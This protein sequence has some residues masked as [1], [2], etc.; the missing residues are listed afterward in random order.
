MH[1]TIELI[2]LYASLK[3]CTYAVQLLWGLVGATQ[4]LDAGRGTCTYIYATQPRVLV[5][6]RTQRKSS[7]SISFPLNIYTKYL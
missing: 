1:V 3:L 2:K 5:W 4:A 6:A 7:L